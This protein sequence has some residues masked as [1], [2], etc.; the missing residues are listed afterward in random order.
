D[1]VLV[2]LGEGPER[3][4]LSTLARERGVES[5]V[6]LPGRVPDVTAWLRRADVYAQPA[7]WEGFGL[8]VLEAMLAGLPVVATNVSSLP[9]LVRDAGILVSPDDPSALATAVNSLLAD[10]ADFGERGLARARAEFSVA[11]MADRT[12]AVYESAWR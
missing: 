9:E 2:V 11:K 1:V 3:S 4:S 5:R 6:F 7:R 8:A 10:P 12:L